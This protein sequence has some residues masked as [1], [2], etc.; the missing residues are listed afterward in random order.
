[1]PEPVMV[2]RG[3]QQSLLDQSP[4]MSEGVVNDLKAIAGLSDEQVAA[5][6]QRL[7]EATGFLDPKSLLATIREAAED[8]KAA[9]AVRR[10]LHS[11]SPS[12]IEHMVA[13]L[14]E[15]QKDEKFPIDQETLGRLKQVLS[16]LIQPYPAL[17]RFEKAERLARVT[18]QQ[19][20]TVELICDLRPIF[21][22][23]RENLEG[24]MPYT[25]L[26]I[27]VTGE[28]GL[29]KPFEA[30]LT[31]KDVADLADKAG[32]A[33]SKLDVLRQSIETWLPGCLPDLPLTRVPRK[34]SSDA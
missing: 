23:N 15:K 2:I 28:D 14:E 29:P 30:E 24:M 26:H 22:E 7:Q 1:M 20:E 34:E 21:D 12:G 11:L 17:A 8:P 9:E 13:S 25:R 6:G 18:G 27:V 3:F 10:A 19:L 33:K 32:K 16:E 5:I 4:I 31:Y